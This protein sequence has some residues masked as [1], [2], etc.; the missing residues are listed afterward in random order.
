MVSYVI[1]YVLDKPFH[2]HKRCGLKRIKT[3][4]DNKVIVDLK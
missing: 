3:K 2:G 1:Y 4:T